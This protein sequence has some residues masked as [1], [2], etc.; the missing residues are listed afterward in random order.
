MKIAIGS[1]HAGYKLKQTI[2]THLTNKGYEVEDFGTHTE[3][4]CDYPD[5]AHAVANSVENKQA[6]LGILMCGSGNGITIAAN[7]HQGIRAALSWDV[8]I[9]QLARLHNDAN[10]VSLPARFIS[11]EKALQIVD[12]FLT[13]EF[14]GGRHQKRVD[15]ISL[16][17]KG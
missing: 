4:S 1:D 3:E 7:K 8:E 9:A 5:Y 13:T 16:K 6:E 10:I 17:V 2:I 14:E 11:E 12:I 15:K